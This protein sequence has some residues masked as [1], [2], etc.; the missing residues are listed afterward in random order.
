[1]QEDMVCV[2]D[3]LDEIEKAELLE[4]E[5]DDQITTFTSV[6]HAGTIICC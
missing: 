4:A 3:V 2:G 5:V 6:C 1:M